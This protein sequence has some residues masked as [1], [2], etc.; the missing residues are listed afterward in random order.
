[1]LRVDLRSFSDTNIEYSLTG[2][3][4]TEYLPG[5]Q[6]LVDTYAGRQIDLTLHLAGLVHVDDACLV[7]L[8]WGEGR[9]VRLSGVS[10]LLLER[11]R[12]CHEETPEGT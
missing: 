4:T 6:H 12:H 2:S 11:L 1:M 3:L 7:Y 5:L 10:A 8:V 9:S